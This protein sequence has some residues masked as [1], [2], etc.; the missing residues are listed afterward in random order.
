M[1]LIA[2]PQT[3]WT[4]QDP[5]P[6]GLPWGVEAG[7]ALPAMPA[8]MARRRQ[9]VLAETFS[10]SIVPRLILAR[11]AAPASPLAA[12]GNDVMHLADILLN[13]D[14]TAAASFVGAVGARGVPVEEVYLTLLAPAARHLGALWDEDLCDFVQVTIGLGWLRQVLGGLTRPFH[15]DPY[16]Q[17]RRHRVLLVPAPGD[18]HSFGMAMVAAFFERAGWTGWSGVPESPAELLRRV[19]TE[20]YAVMGFSTSCTER[21]DALSVAIRNVRRVSMNPDIRIMVGGPLFIENPEF[22]AMVGAD[23]TASDGQQAVLQAQRLLALI[24]IR[25]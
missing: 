12:D 14:L 10:Q 9:D 21:L 15:D 8:F 5:R 20:S 23:A 17:A 7:E 2:Q 22:V 16:R 4:R 13:Q 6:D 25:A 1:P 19:R 11:G 24:P 3:T 18:T